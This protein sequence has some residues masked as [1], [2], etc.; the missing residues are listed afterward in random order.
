MGFQIVP[1]SSSR[2]ALG[3]ALP[4]GGTPYLQM[5]PQSSPIDNTLWDVRVMFWGGESAPCSVLGTAIIHRK[6]GLPLRW[7]GYDQ[8]VEL[9]TD[10]RD[11]GDSFHSWIFGPKVG[12]SYCYVMTSDTRFGGYTLQ[13]DGNTVVVRASSGTDDGY[14]W[15]IPYD[16]DQG[17]QGSASSPVAFVSSWTGD[18]SSRT[19]DHLLQGTSAGAVIVTPIPSTG[20]TKDMQWQLI[21]KLVDQVPQNTQLI[22]NVEL[23]TYLHAAGIAGL[24][25][26]AKVPP[27]GHESVRPSMWMPART[28]LVNGFSIPCPTFDAVATCGT[29]SDNGVYLRNWAGTNNQLWTFAILP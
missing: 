16:G 14:W 13:V 3:V 9:G 12:E 7:R 26:V 15:F 4:P 5:M 18:L 23:K 19:G 17:D 25:L 28:P 2:I 24:N 11:Y 29:G 6:T 21:T 10:P 20:I 27:D 22:R 1:R 8:Q